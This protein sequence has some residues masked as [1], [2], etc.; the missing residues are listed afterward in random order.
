[1][2]E[3][4]D[5][6]KEL[7]EDKGLTQEIVANHLNINRATLSAYET[8]TNE[9]NLDTLVAIADFFNVSCDYILRRTKNPDIINFHDRTELINKI[10][11]MLKNYDIVR[12]KKQ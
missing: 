7:R 6:I 11:L 9:P 4:G 5:I 3:I 12:L 8:N 10:S 2:R 1:M